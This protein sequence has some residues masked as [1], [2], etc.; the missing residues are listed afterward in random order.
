MEWSGD[1]GGS[2]GLYCSQVGLGM[3]L[4]RSG[5]V[6][7][8]RVVSEENRIPQEVLATFLEAKNVLRCGKRAFL[9]GR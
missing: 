5:R 2:T 9:M 6:R 1:E 3:L 7:D 8:R 4:S